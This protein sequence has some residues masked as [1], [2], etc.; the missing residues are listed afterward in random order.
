VCRVTLATVR[1]SSFSTS[2]PASSKVSIP[3][4]HAPKNH[5]L[6]PFLVSPSIDTFCNNC[7]DILRLHGQVA[8]RLGIREPSDNTHLLVLNPRCCYQAENRQSKWRPRHLPLCNPTAIAELPGTRLGISPR[9]PLSVATHHLL[10]SPTPKDSLPPL[11][12]CEVWALAMTPT[13]MT[14]SLPHN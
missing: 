12:P 1:R 3:A 4:T 5:L 13:T 10:L 7:A 2:D 6:L 8:N 9:G 11:Y 14:Y